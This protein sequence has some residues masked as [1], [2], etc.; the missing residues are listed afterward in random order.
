MNTNESNA[1][2]A[3]A[4]STSDTP[5]A[6]KFLNFDDFSQF[7]EVNKIYYNLKLNQFFK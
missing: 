6:S 4:E 5:L 1:A 7:Y 3:A 2:A